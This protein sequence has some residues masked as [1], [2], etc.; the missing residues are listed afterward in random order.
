M[1]VRKALQIAAQIA[2]G[3]AAAHKRGLVHRD[4]KPENIMITTDGV[5]KILDFGLAKSLDVDADT[6][7]SEPGMLVGTYRLH[8]ARAGPRRRDRLSLRPV[9]VRLDPLR[10]AHRQP[11]LRRRERRGDAVHGRA[12]RAAAAVDRGARTCPRRCAG[13]STAASP[14]IRTTATSSTRDLARDLQYIRDHFSEAGVAT[15]IREKDSL[16][17]AHPQALARRRGG[18]ARARRR[19]AG[20]G[21]GAPPRAARRSPP[22]A[23][24]RTPAHDYSPAVS[25]DGKLIAFASAR[26][27]VQRIWLKQV[28]G[29]SEVALTAGADDFPRF[30]PDGSAVLYI[31]ADPDA[32]PRGRSGASGRRRRAAAHCSTT[33]TSADFSPDGTQLAF[34][35]PVH[36]NG[37]GARR[38]LR[39]RRRRLERAR[40]GA[41]RHRRRASALVAGRQVDR[42]RDRRAAGAS[43]RRSMIVDVA[44]G[45][46]EDAGHA[47]RKRARCRRWSGPRT[48]AA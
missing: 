4:L 31:H 39:R 36:E 19:L 5:V 46:R 11:R 30:S 14:R 28:A 12:R 48:A 25:P 3:L 15:P 33:S 10:D 9:L 16:T 8:V 41:L 13:S 32:A 29:G 43:R 26:D 17:H 7:V 38:A 18:R 42:H 6:N 20:H 35:R 22:S 21:L 47:G 44:T 24:S 40:A 1:P 2:D 27:G 45:K 23:I 34:T 37:V